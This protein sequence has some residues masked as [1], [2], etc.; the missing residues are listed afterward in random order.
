[1]SEALRLELQAELF[2]HFTYHGL[3]VVL[4]AVHVPGWI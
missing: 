3:Q 2:A 4:A 1:V